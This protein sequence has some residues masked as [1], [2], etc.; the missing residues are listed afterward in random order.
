MRAAVLR[1][2]NESFEIREDVALVDP[3][4][5]EVLV[6]LAACGVCH[7][8]LSVLNGTMGAGTFPAILGHEGAGTVI[9]VG[10]GVETLKE[11]DAVVLAFA[12]PCGSCRRCLGRQP[13]LCMVGYAAMFRTK[14][15]FSIDGEGV[16]AMGPG[17]FSERTVVPAIAAIKIPDDIP[18]EVA[19]LVGCGAMTG[20]GAVINTA[21]VEP[22]SSVVVVGCGGVGTAVIQGARLAGAADIVAVDLVPSK[23][24]SAK[25]FGATAAVHPDQLADARKEITGGEGF[26]YAFEVIGLGE[27]I[28]AAYD[29]TR[30]GGTTV[31]V[32]AGSPKSEVT[33]TARELFFDEKRFLGSFY[34][35]A[36]VR[37]DFLKL[38]RLWRAG[39]LDLEGMI[40]RRVALDDL[41][42]AFRAMT[43]GEVV[44]SVVVY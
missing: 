30:R 2:V 24:E 17:A 5:G 44:R 43:A 12:P 11:G 3:G 14:P 23:L 16:W 7:S 41:D 4:P 42:D 20:V 6:D 29:A 8:D 25:R 13:N 32:G 18:L 21:K 34:G 9:G 37:S 38:L 33:F 40:T 1:G 31:V 26:D 28:R 22:G 19:S 27:T 35:S 39:R 10:P 15:R 36:D